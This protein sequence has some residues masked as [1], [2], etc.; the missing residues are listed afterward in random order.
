M[1]RRIASLWTRSPRAVL[2][3]CAL[4]TIVLA[5]YAVG[6]PERLGLGGGTAAGSPSERAAD[7]LAAELGYDPEP[8]FLLVLSAT[9][10]VGPA[11]EKVAVRATRG[12]VEEIDGVAAVRESGRSADGLTT[13]LAVYLRRDADPETVAAVWEGLR[14]GLDP[15]PYRLLLGGRVPTAEGARDALLDDALTLE[16]VALPLVLLVLVAWLGPWLGLAALLGALLALSASGAV[17][18]LA[19]EL[20]RLDAMSVVAAAAVGIVLAVE[21]SAA[22]VYRYREESAS[23]GG[24][25]EALEYSLRTVLGGAAIGMFSAAL[26][27]A[28]LCAIPISSV[29]SVGAGVVVAALVA[30]PLALLPVAAS[31]SMRAG[32][33][34]GEALPLVSE[35]AATATGPAGYRLLF[36][37][38]RARRRGLL[39]LAPLVVVVVAALPLLDSEAIG[40][41]AAELPAGQP[42]AAA[43]A[44]LSGA[45]GTGA[46]GPLTVVADGAP[47]AELGAYRGAISELSSVESVGLAAPAGGLS[48]FD[49]VPASRPRSLAA[50][51]TAAAIAAVPAPVASAI[52]GPAAAVR[53]ASMRLS[54]DLPLALLVALLGTAALWSALFRAAFGPLLALAAAIAPL[55]GLGTMVWVFGGGR[56]SGLLDYAPAGAP[57]LGSYVVVGTA[58]LAIALWRGAQTA[59]ALH[60]ERQLGG[61][62]AGSL[63]RAGL[64][65]LI[66][67]AIASL[68]GIVTI[69]IWLGAPLTAA[70]EVALGLSAGLL[71]DFVLTRML[72]AP[73]LA[74]LSIQG[75]G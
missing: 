40:L 64:L 63:A 10:P 48:H 43:D 72:I 2:V 33:E 75:A 69:G 24:G 37:L 67:A 17:L 39:V 22:L 21:A 41:D 6:V 3:V 18:G 16:L 1:T 23:L 44:E 60:E 31:L 66:P 20:I 45:F 62:A 8:A 50:Q 59:N 11:A 27:G 61:G 73:A 58:L 35:R 9:E 25:P 54:D 42:A 5:A 32:E 26:V 65:T 13:A 68:A 51:R 74:R 47:G 57:H 19:G 28:A 46:G 4:A 30:P 15:G 49:A 55:L 14:G 56:L 34:I 38:G 70:K 7:A 29:Q 71:A 12:Q 36:G 53:D 52:T